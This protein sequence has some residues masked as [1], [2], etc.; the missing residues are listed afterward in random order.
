MRTRAVLLTALLACVPVTL[1]SRTAPKLNVGDLPPPKLGWHVKLDDYRG[2]IVIVTFW[3]SWC[4]PCRKELP[5]LEGIQ[6]QA[7]TEKIQV[8]AVNWREGS[9]QFRTIQRV[10]KGAT[11]TLLSDEGGSIGDQYGVHAIPHMVILGRDG[12]IAAIHIG[13]AEQEI[14]E[15][16]DEINELWRKG[17]QPD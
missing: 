4:G 5:L 14:P 1:L 11:I 9:E 2:K 6:K 15:L 17:S 7:T 8:F 13:Y 10:L 3:A 12:R 16:V